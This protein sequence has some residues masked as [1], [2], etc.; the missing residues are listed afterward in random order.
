MPNS[1]QSANVTA[2][3][4][5]KNKI[6][7]LTELTLLCREKQQQQEKKVKYTTCH[8]WINAKKKKKK[9]E[10]DARKWLRRALEGSYLNKDKK[11]AATLRQKHSWF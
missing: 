9:T 5:N 6:T 4:N 11:W 2:V 8:M 1:T 10:K 7:T 3:N